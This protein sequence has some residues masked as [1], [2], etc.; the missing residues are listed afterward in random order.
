MRRLQLQTS[1]ALRK[2]QSLMQAPPV[3]VYL[4]VVLWSRWVSFLNAH[5]QNDSSHLY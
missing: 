5:I 3:Q 1:I 2:H 4:W